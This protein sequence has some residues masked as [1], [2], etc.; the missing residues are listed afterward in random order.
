MIISGLLLAFFVS[1]LVHIFALA[2]YVTKK[3]NR[4]LKTYITTTFTN[5]A[6]AGACIVLIFL[7]PEMAKEVDIRF[8]VWLMSGIILVIT[9]IIKIG[10]FKRIYRRMKDPSNYHVNFFGKKVLHASVVSRLE[11]AVFFGTVPFFL[12][13]GA[14]F[15]ARGVNFFLYKHL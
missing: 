14:Y 12:M 5:I 2:A 10:V 11:I 6:L 15:V 8:L 3:S 13:A 7:K 1:F 9:I 4:S